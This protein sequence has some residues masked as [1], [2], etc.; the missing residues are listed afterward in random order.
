MRLGDRGVR[1]VVRRD[2][3]TTPAVEDA[4]FM[5]SLDA[6]MKES[7]VDHE[8]ECAESCQHYFCGEASNADAVEVQRYPMGQ[9]PSIDYPD[10]FNKEESV[11]V[12][13]R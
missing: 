12:T 9:V 1:G 3:D 5:A 7:A 10:A 13:L 4:D 2:Q 11:Y 6:N 8:R